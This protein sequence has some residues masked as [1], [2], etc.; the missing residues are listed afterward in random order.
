MI[1]KWV[2]EIIMKLLHLTLSALLIFAICIG[3]ASAAGSGTFSANNALD[4]KQGNNGTV[5]IYLNNTFDPPAG[6]LTFDLTYDQTVAAARDVVS[7]TA[8]G[9]PAYNQLDSPITI[10]V[11]T[12]TTGIPT[13]NTWLFQIP[14]E[15][16]KNDGSSTAL[17]LSLITLDDAID[18]NDLIPS[19]TVV[20]GTFSTLDEV[21]PVVT[22]TTSGTVS[23][24][25]AVAGTITDVGGMGT[26]SVTLTGLTS[27]ET[28]TF[29]LPLTPAA[30]VNTWTFS[31][32]VDWPTYEDVRV[33]VTATDAAG[34]SGSDDAIIT[35]SPVGFSDPE[36]TG[37]LNAQPSVIRVFTQQMNQSTV[38]MTLTGP[39]TIPLGVT[40][41]GGYAE[42]T[43][44]PALADGTWTVTAGGT[45]TTG[46]TQ[47]LDWSFTLDTVPPTI[48]TFAITDT[49]GDGYIEAGETLTLTWDVADLNFANVSLVDTAT[50][51]VLWTNSNRAGTTT[52]A[53]TVGNRDLEF[54]AYDLA[55]N[56]AKRSFHLYYNYM[57]WVNS[58]RMGTIS[59]IDTNLTAMRQFDLT[60]Q[61]SVIFYNARD[62]PFPALGAIARSVT[63]VGQVTSDTYVTVDNTANTTYTGADTYDNVWTYDPGSVLDFEVQAP[64]IK[65][66]NLMILEANESY[67][68]QLIDEGRAAEDNLNYNDLI[69]K[70]AWI[71]IDGGYTKIEVNPDGTFSQ[72]VADGA[73]LTVA[74]SGK[75]MDTLA[76]SANQVDL[77]AGYRLSAQHLADPSFPAG[78]YVLAAISVDGDRI[79]LIDGM[80][81][82]VMDTN[83][84]GTV[85]ALVDRGTDFDAS[86]PTPA[87]RV[88]AVVVRDA[89]WDATVGIDASVLNL[90]MISA[91]LTYNDIPAT[92]K[93]IGNVYATPDAAAYAV[94][95]NTTTVS[96]STDGLL[97][98]TYHVYLLAEDED[99]TVQAYGH[100]QIRV[101]DPD[102]PVANFTASPTSGT[103]PLT[104]TFT[105]YSTGNITSRLWA[106]GD[107]ATATTQNATHTYAAGTYT[108]NLTVTGPLGNDSMIQTIT[109]TA[110][111]SPSH[112]GG[113]GGG[114]SV[115][116]TTSTGSAT[117]LTASWGSVLK[118]YRIYSDEKIAN[119]YIPTGVV[120][121]D[122][123]GEP[124][125]EITISDL[126]SDEMPA[127]PD[128]VTYTFMGYAVKCTPAGAT[129]SPAIDLTF[130]LDNDQWARVLD[131]AD[132]RVDTLVVKWYNP[133]TEVWEHVPTTIDAVQH[134]VTASV[135]HF[136]IFGLFS[137]TA[138]ETPVTQE[139]TTPPTTVTPATTVSTTTTT[140]TPTPSGGEGFPWLW[141]LVII[142]IILVAV[143]VY[144]YL[145]RR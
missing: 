33:A 140:T 69:Q 32:N 83:E 80:P 76:L 114:S 7:N 66:A 70:S 45:D 119:L 26:A 95:S 73:A 133:L 64:D 34:N 60:A 134:T 116:T 105:D 47:S 29:G 23:S 58:T 52:T 75:I 89:T 56:Y 85:P 118:P 22:I 115:T 136:S 108:A 18:G 54:R 46:G 14:M 44:V 28:Q 67:L 74:T 110:A 5:E 128:G 49:D 97:S 78:D 87:R 137:D 124:V 40:F 123:D 111:P 6:S 138:V 102:A 131:K 127:V 68:A 62:V 17:T 57:A 90:D 112:G 125:S 11:I 82:T 142:V 21:P 59:G 20:N 38:T 81:F 109:V 143:G 120:A 104:V 130:T 100:H 42:N 36:P 129:F 10:G 141:V 39:S 16:L 35:V 13:G 88:A 25:F 61:G 3:A 135:S 65:G 98:G 103:A 1:L 24:T 84:V 91:S 27:G 63:H 37:Y 79:G 71:F 107:G 92:K 43:S 121:L 145:Q 101:H 4:I 117:L 126:G 15:A 50:D 19:T 41:D 55:G 106:F 96:V 8:F 2:D 94:A 86:F 12:S 144:F 113:G 93:L 77:D 53:I 31:E 99:G 72:P 51:A 30:A 132:G 122:E 9:T 48:S 139:P